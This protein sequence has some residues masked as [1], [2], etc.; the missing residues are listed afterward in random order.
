MSGKKPKE[1]PARGLS[2]RLDHSTAWSAVIMKSLS[3]QV[4][5]ADWKAAQRAKETANNRDNYEYSDGDEGF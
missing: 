4:W 1:R 2:V 3:E 5:P